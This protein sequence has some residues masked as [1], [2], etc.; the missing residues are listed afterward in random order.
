MAL[1][2]EAGQ[3]V[4]FEYRAKLA[5]QFVSRTGRV[6]KAAS[7]GVLLQEADPARPDG[8]RFRSY[9][10]YDSEKCQNCKVLTPARK[11]RHSKRDARGRFAR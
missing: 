9:N 5:A 1:A 3:I 6:V 7:W 4:R 8:E 2:L 10:V 11:G